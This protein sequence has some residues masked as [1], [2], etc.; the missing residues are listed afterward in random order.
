MPI[1]EYTCTSCEHRFEELVL[2]SRTLVACPEC[3]SQDVEKL[4]SVF[5]RIGGG[6]EPRATG[7][8]GGG[9]CGGGCGCSR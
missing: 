4:L 6:D 7:G 8:G 9:C 1:Y 3:T 2:G 5:A